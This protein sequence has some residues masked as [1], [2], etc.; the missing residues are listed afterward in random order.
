MDSYFPA[1]K[2]GAQAGLTVKDSSRGLNSLLKAPEKS[3]PAKPVMVSGHTPVGPSLP[4]EALLSAPVKPE[5]RCIFAL[6][7]QSL[8]AGQLPSTPTLP[9][10]EIEQREI[11]A[12]LHGCLSSGSSGSLYVSGSPGVGKTAVVVSA[13]AG[14]LRGE[15]WHRAV[16]VRQA[17]HSHTVFT[18][19]SP[20]TPLQ[21]RILAALPAWCASQGVPAPVIHS[22][23]GLTTDWTPA[24]LQD[25]LSGIMKSVRAGVSSRAGGNIATLAGDDAASENAVY[26]P[27]SRG[28]RGRK[29]VD[30]AP[31]SDCSD[32]DEEHDE[33]ADESR[34]ASSP[35]KK[36]RAGA[37]ASAARGRS[38][39]VGA[40]SIPSV[41]RTPARAA[42]AALA[43]SLTSSVSPGSKSTAKGQA[44]L[45]AALSRTKWGSLVPP[46]LTVPAASP[47]GRPGSL[48][49]PSPSP[50]RARDG[51][52]ASSSPTP[53][54]AA[55]AFPVGP[56]L[57]SPPKGTPSTPSPG[58]RGAKASS[59]ASSPS[60]L[61]SAP[62][63][64]ALSLGISPTS[65]PSHASSGA[66]AST[67]GSSTSSG[68]GG[69][70]GPLHIVVVDELDGMLRKGDKQQRALEALFLE[71]A[72]RGSRVVVLGIAN[73]IA[74]TEKFLP[75]LRTVGASPSVVV[76]R[77]YSDA[78]IGEI[79]AQRLAGACEAWEGAQRAARE[80]RATVTGCGGAGR[81][82]AAP[83]ASASPSG[84]PTAAAVA[85]APK[86]AAVAQQCVIDPSAILYL[87]RRVSSKTGDLRRALDVGRKALACAGRVWCDPPP[88]PQQGGS[89]GADDN[90]CDDELGADGL[91]GMQDCG[92]AA[93][94]DVEPS[95]ALVS[96]P[97][98]PKRA[99]GN[100]RGGAAHSAPVEPDV[101]TCACCSTGFAWQRQPARAPA[102]VA[103]PAGM[104]SAGTAPAAPLPAPSPARKPQHY[105]LGLRDLVPVLDALERSYAA[106][107]QALPRQGLVLVCAARALA[108]KE[109][110][111][112]Q[113]IR[114]AQEA[115]RLPDGG[116]V[117]QFMMAPGSAAERRVVSKKEAEERA[118]AASGSN[119]IAVAALERA[120]SSLCRR[121]LLQPVSHSQFTDLVN[122]LA[123]EGMLVLQGGGRG[124]ASA[125]ASVGC[126]AGSAKT[127]R[128]KVQLAD[129]DVALSA[130][131]LYQALAADVRNGTI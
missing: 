26:T 78:Q 131:P 96:P 107:L 18:W 119:P 90:D 45:L 104:T 48:A 70:G 31:E 52:A 125:A 42:L 79:I 15:V 83:G 13:T 115:Q 117:D 43:P 44:Q 101:P 106:S 108:E 124:S 11:E 27:G 118:A 111:D 63:A 53:S 6:A 58:R 95:E 59:A 10:R 28:G 62:F 129:L 30:D 49:L 34:L 123:D 51:A 103:A 102:A 89:L 80:Q 47:R 91:A 121:K 60:S 32:A 40:P 114:D 85:T 76:F 105:A 17:A 64:T 21:S 14:I 12:F 33:D 3:Q 122:R 55:S 39:S 61:L 113:A 46:G 67:S 116:G 84:T 24:E 112:T 74:M 68:S 75:S 2:P 109:A 41:V 130:S 73:A 126:G 93:E 94:P 128:V 87:A 54:R 56:L 69:A 127:V 7:S 120:Y 8:H 97:A 4:P 81:K 5:F 37:S 23:N 1:R 77:P 86:P 20:P 98:S 110:R 92:M 71:P 99:S 72:R 25:L 100:K 35:V 65:S 36:R 50:P 22:Y 38:T 29:L 88:A 57:T 9:C 16:D 66:N 82:R 19:L